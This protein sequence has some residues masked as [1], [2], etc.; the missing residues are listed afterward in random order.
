MKRIN[1]PLYCEGLPCS[2]VAVS[3]A[4]DNETWSNSPLIAPGRS[5]GYVTL[6]EMNKFVRHNLAV[7]KRIDFKRGERPKLKHLPAVLKKMLP[8]I[9]ERKAIVCVLGHYLYFD[10]KD[11]YSFFNNKEDDVVA[12][13][14]LEDGLYG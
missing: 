5:D 4:L 2:V 1:P 13:W 10:G 9:V 14:V 3:C 12:V 6:Q 8:K 7:K 11:Y